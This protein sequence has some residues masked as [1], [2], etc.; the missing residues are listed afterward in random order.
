ME[1]TT[2]EV[3]SYTKGGGESVPKEYGERAGGVMVVGW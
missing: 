2:Q 1:L 3:D